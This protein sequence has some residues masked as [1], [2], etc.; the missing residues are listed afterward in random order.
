V[1]ACSKPTTVDRRTL[2]RRL[3]AVCAA[4]PLVPCALR[5]QSSPLKTVRWSERLLLVQGPDSNSLVIDGRDGIALV[6][7]GHAAWSNALLAA[8]NEN[9]RGRPLRALVNTHWHDEQTGANRRLGEQGVEI[10]AHENTKLWLG[11]EVWV[12]WSDKKYPPLPKAAQPATTFYESTDAE[13]AGRR[14]QYVYTPKAHTDGDIAVFFPDD[15]VL[16]A[17]GFVSNAGWPVIDWWTGGWTGGMLEGFERLAEVANTSTRIVPANGAPMTLA[18]L[19]AQQSMYT[20]VF[21]RIH[22]LLAKAYGTDEVL[23]AKPT[24][25][26]DAKFGDPRLFVTLAFQSTWGH[27]RDAYDTRLRNIA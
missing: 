18:E 2:L 3:V 1:S 24:A 4:L 13:L 25:E 16:A 17:P 11:S 12:R 8:V 22:D 21:G 5:A 20:T 10:V 7:G 6:G 26:Y 9:F 15:N 27:L 23:A 19:E 14:V